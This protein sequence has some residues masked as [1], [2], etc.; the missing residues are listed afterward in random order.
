MRT[1]ATVRGQSM[2]DGNNCFGVCYL[3][4]FSVGFEFVQ[5]LLPVRIEH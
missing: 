2:K 3:T 5:I 4:S 1:A